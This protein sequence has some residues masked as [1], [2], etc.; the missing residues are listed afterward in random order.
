MGLNRCDL[1]CEYGFG[2]VRDDASERHSSLRDGFV[3]DFTLRLSVIW[4]CRS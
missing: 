3:L 4:A 1:G 2:A